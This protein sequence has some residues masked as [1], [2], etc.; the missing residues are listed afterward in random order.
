ML[1]QKRLLIQKYTERKNVTIIG[2][3]PSGVVLRV[4]FDVSV[5]LQLVRPPLVDLETV[6]VFGVEVQLLRRK[7]SQL[8]SHL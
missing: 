7:I 4:H 8:H 1:V 5:V 2:P 3:V 6:S